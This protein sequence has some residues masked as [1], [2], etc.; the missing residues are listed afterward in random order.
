MKLELQIRHI[1]INC[2]LNWHTRQLIRLDFIYVQ[3]IHTALG[4]HPTGYRTCRDNTRK[5]NKNS[6]ILHSPYNM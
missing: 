6:I 3:L 5:A 4:D 1:Q 2:C